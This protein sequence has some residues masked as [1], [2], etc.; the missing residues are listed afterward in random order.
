[1]YDA[2]LRQHDS[3]KTA[4]QPTLAFLESPGVDGV[5]AISDWNPTEGRLRLET[6]AVLTLAEVLLHCR[7][8]GQPA[9][10]RAAIELMTRASEV[11]RQA[12][13]VATTRGISSHGS[14][15]PWRLLLT[16]DGEV[17]VAGVG[18]PDVELFSYLDGQQ[19]G[20][21]LDTLRYAPPERLEDLEE[22]HRSDLYTIALVGAE[23]ALGRPV[24]DGAPT[25]VAERVLRGDAPELIEAIG[26]SLGDDVLDLLCVATELHPDERFRDFKEF[27]A[28]ARALDAS[29]PTLAELVQQALAARPGAAQV[30]IDEPEEEIEPDD[31][32][33]RPGIEADFEL[34]P[35]VPTLPA[36]ADLATA[37]DHARAIADRARQ[38]A[39][40]ADAMS[41]IARQRAHAQPTVAPL[42]RRVQDA[43]GKA[44]KAARSTQNAAKL[45]DLDDA[46]D[47][48]LT[49]LEMVRSAE[50]LCVAST[51]MALD[52]LGALQAQID[53]L[54]AEQEQHERAK[55]L[56][57][58]Y[59]DR[60]DAATTEA[61]DESRSLDQQLSD[62]AYS[63]QGAADL[64]RAAIDNATDARQNA[65][66]A[67]QQ[68]KAVEEQER[69]ADALRIAERLR[70][71]AEETEE[72]RDA[73]RRVARQLARGEA[74]ALEALRTK[75]NGAVSR[76]ESAH[77]VAQQ[78]SERAH[79]ATEHAPIKDREQRLQ[80]LD[81]HVAIAARAVEEAREGLASLPTQGGAGRASATVEK[82]EAAAETAR[83]AAD[84]AIEHGDRLVEQAGE[85]A[86]RQ[87]KMSKLLAEIEQLRE[88]IQ[89]N[90]NRVT[91]AW[92]KLAADTAEV[93]GRTARDAIQV[94]NKAVE[95][96][97]QVATHA[98]DEPAERDD[99]TGLERRA[100]RLRD[101]I[102]GLVD[103]GERAISRC[104]EARG[105]ASRELEEI[106]E[107]RRR[108]EELERAI[109]RAQGHAERCAQA[110][111]IAWER[112]HETVELLSSAGIQAD[113][114]QR[115]RAYEIIDIAEY[116][117]GEAASAAQMASDQNDP[118][119]ARS[120]ASTAASFEERITTDLPEAMALLDALGSEARERIARLEKA[121][122]RLKKARS[123]ARE[124]I[125]T[126]EEALARSRELARHWAESDAVQDA[127]GRIEHA[128]DGTEAPLEEVKSASSRVDEVED[129]GRLESLIPVAEA[130]A[131]HLHGTAQEVERRAEALQK[132]V[133]DTREETEARESAL[134]T[135]RR[136]QDAI[137]ELRLQLTDRAQRLHG[138]IETHAANGPAVSKARDRMRHALEV[139]QAALDAVRSAN[140]SILDTG[141]A[142][143]ARA[144]ERG[145]SEQLHK[146]EQQV[147]IA[148]EAETEGINAAE[149]EA[150]ER[151]EKEERELKN[152]RATSLQHVQTAKEAAERG[153]SVLK[154]ATRELAGVDNPEV[155]LLH[156]AARTLVREARQAASATLQAARRCQRART[157]E[158]ALEWEARAASGAGDA[159]QAIVD[160]ALKIRQAVDIARRAE[161]E[162][163]ALA[164]V[165]MEVASLAG[166]ADGYDAAASDAVAD[167]RKITDG[168]TDPLTLAVNDEADEALTSVQRLIEKLRT[169]AQMGADA[170][171]LP[172]AQ[173]LLDTCRKTQQR[174][175]E[176]QQGLRDLVTKAQQLRSEEADRAAARLNEARSQ[177]EAPSAEARSIAEKARGWLTSGQ[178][179]V[180]ESGESAAALEAFLVLEEAVETVGRLA[181]Q[182][183]QAAQPAKRAATVQLAK[184]LGDR[185]RKA[186]DRT[187]KAA[188]SAKSALKDLR[189]VAELANAARQAAQQMLEDAK[190]TVAEAQSAANTA[191]QLAQELEQYLTDAGINDDDVASQFREVTR[192]AKAV[193]QAASVAQNLQEEAAEKPYD[194]VAEA[195]QDIGAQRD[196]AISTLDELKKHDAACREQLE[197][198]KKKA[199]EEAKR[200]KD[201]ALRARLRRKRNESTAMKREELKRRF[202]QRDEAEEPRKPNLSVLRERLRARRRAE[203]DPRAVVAERQDRPRRRRRSSPDQ[204][205]LMLPEEESESDVQLEPEMLESPG[206]RS[207]EEREE[208][209]RRR[210]LRRLRRQSMAPRLQDPPTRTEV[211]L[212]NPGE[213]EPEDPDGADGADALLRRLRERQRRKN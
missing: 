169:A 32:D 198:K 128:A 194:Q 207:P 1:M 83:R 135:A 41:V 166:D 118:T 160:A 154:E 168:S 22:D 123:T 146:V 145:I 110:V 212:I 186:A 108:Q 79:T 133:A 53:D 124:A 84:D 196:I 50:N 42:L 74:D 165:K 82:I 178:R 59:V 24:F 92:E 206:S 136:C 19:G 205:S 147:E 49:T 111:K 75:A 17:Q 36:D 183:E 86:A 152:A 190:S 2:A 70:K 181:A 179:V 117:A 40:Q 72:A 157:A 187:L 127:L 94:A 27:Q 38:L 100:S 65:R 138:A 191:T 125:R 126:I 131:R 120:H 61:R 4:I 185:V 163:E 95:K 167:V 12:A 26:A 122:D 89:N 114:A 142:A 180:Q 20:V 202:Q 15:S 90:A 211:G 150:A 139:A 33:T 170:D 192:S 161:E 105:A 213:P 56:A 51:E 182:A 119:E 87:A 5:I 28:Q 46:L 9:G 176:E 134:K 106:A 76:A 67:K 172:V 78:S 6:D 151:V 162:A 47:D 63:V 137:A 109:E 209:R 23:M 188:E 48:A 7:R 68:S 3:L 69:G 158:E 107:R 164:N 177:A 132:V 66:R 10:L 16:P 39:E 159:S 171:S 62:G 60:I 141:S 77:R 21:S 175:Q 14:L 88:E 210:E 37:K 64:V 193:A 199:K 144:L 97:Q 58:E 13:T 57:A 81:R 200:Q 197:G 96:V 45:V 121:R 30:A 104:R 29:G 34:V 156:K 101:A 148:V 102:D 80:T 43:V 85:A 25:E 18:L 93:A 8:A 174:V 99:L 153:V 44:H 189:G 208:S 129:A 55:R 11:L 204:S 52:A 116:Q 73:I 35:P 143:E 149:R 140:S 130:A 54:R 201:E 113:A 71:L 203:P 195:V 91:Q 112:Y 98:L 184:S 155:T 31:T 115:A 173:K 103:L